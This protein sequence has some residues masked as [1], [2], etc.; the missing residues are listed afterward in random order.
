MTTYTVGY[1]VGSLSA[2]S[3][4]RILSKALVRLAPARLVVRR[5]PDQ[6]SSAV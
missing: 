4:N 1:I 6:G 2:Q 3:I 5:N